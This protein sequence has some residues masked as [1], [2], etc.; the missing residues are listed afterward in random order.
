MCVRASACQSCPRRLAVC[1]SVTVLTTCF[2]T[3]T[4]RSP[5]LVKQQH[6][7]AGQRGVAHDSAGP[8]ESAFC[9]LLMC[10]FSW[11]LVVRC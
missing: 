1:L 2:V 8:L 4:Q 5:Q 11:P 9:L 7:G 10:F 6:G 3:G